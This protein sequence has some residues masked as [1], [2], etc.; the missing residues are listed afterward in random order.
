[1]SKI[2]SGKIKEAL[3]SVLPVTAV[4]IIVNFFL[5]DPL[6]TF[7]LIAFIAGA[8]L[9]IAGITLYSL[10]TD[11]ALSPIGESVGSKLMGTGNIVFILFIS[12]A[13]GFLIT[14]AEPDLLILGTQLG[15][16]KVLLIIVVS[17]GVGLFLVAALL[18]IFLK[19]SLNIALIALY[20]LVFILV[21]FVDKKYIPLSFDSG[22][23][24]TG[25]VTVPFII[26]LGAGVAAVAGVKNRNADSFGIIALCSVGPIAAV[27]LIS[28]IFKP[29]I[30][31]S[32]Y[33]AEIAD[34]G[35][36]FIHLLA[37]LASSAIDIAIAVFPIAMLFFIFNAFLIRMPRAKTVK[38]LIG[39]LYIY[40]GLTL[41]LTGIK[42]GFM[43]AGLKLGE[44]TAAIGDGVFIII[45]M[46]VGALTI[47]AEPAVHVLCKQVENLSNGK[48][49]KITIMLSLSL[50]VVLATG[51]ALLRVVL[52]I[53]I[54]YIVLPGYALAIVLSFFSPKIFTAIA[55]DS[56]G[57]ASGPMATTFMLPF[58]IGGCAAT[59]GGDAVFSYAYGLV[60]FIALTPLITIQIIGIIVK[61]SE[62]TRAPL[63]ADVIAKLE[64]D[65]VILDKPTEKLRKKV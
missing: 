30:Q 61:L 58:A 16:I 33:A 24:T 54:L 5:P 36:Y 52:K 35:G 65:I 23:V 42:S 49:K 10:G 2:L 39:I 64:G 17:V 37:S 21:I 51:L 7:E 43:T 19:I 27:L 60:A 14:I 50:S 8:A 47:F 59:L 46:A 1:M 26:S 41:F 38:I 62:R 15:D 32:I 12:F 45:G 40:I 34:A 53:D 44:Q 6:S 3:F 48:I 25:A 11:S 20:A 29:E 63:E 22:G 18:R 55:F 4:V 56:G 31:Q 28:A 13:I 9:M 57:V